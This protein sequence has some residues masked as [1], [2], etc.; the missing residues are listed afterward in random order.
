MGEN[1]ERKMA[2][3]GGCTNEK[4]EKKKVV[5]SEKKKTEILEIQHEMKTGRD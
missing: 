2:R 5:R 3:R 1:M 4:E